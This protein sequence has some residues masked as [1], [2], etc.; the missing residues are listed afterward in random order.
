[1]HID[2][3]RAGLHA[4][5]SPDLASSDYYLFRSM[6][7]GFSEQHF[8]FYEEVKN[9]IDEWLASNDERWYWEGIQ[10]PKRW[11]KVISNDGTMIIEFI[12]FVIRIKA[13]FNGKTAVSYANT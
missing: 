4:P 13:Y 2:I 9:W 11:K 12:Q 6:Q 1:M 3:F 10:L 7:H 8:N 5:Y